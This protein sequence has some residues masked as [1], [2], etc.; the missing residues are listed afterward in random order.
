MKTASSVLAIAC[1]ALSLSTPGL[2]ASPGKNDQNQKKGDMTIIGK[3]IDSM[4]VQ[5]KGVAGNGHRLLKVR[6]S[7][8]EKMVVD[9]GA[10]G[11]LDKIDLTRGDFLIATGRSARINGRP[12]LYAKYVGELQAA[13]RSG[14]LRFESASDD[15]RNGR[16]EN[17]G[18][19]GNGS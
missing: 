10:V 1:T 8:G 9:V 4:D 18:K 5:L 16:R 3:V 2:A 15:S 11:S 14:E 6:S 12:V 17:R 13:G 19:R 7:D